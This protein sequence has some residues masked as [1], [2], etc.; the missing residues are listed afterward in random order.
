MA[1][2]TKVVAEDKKTLSPIIGTAFFSYVW[3]TLF[4]KTCLDSFALG[5]VTG[6]V[7]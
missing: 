5:F 3:Q 6:F 4:L 7:E 1:S 2:S